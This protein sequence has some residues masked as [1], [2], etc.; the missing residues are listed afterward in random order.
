MFGDFNADIEK[1]SVFGNELVS[2]C[3]DSD[4]IVADPLFLSSGSVTHFNDGHGTESWLDHVV[5]TKGA[6]TLISDIVI[7]CTVCGSDHFPIVTTIA[8]PCCTEPVTS[9]QEAE[10]AKWTV[11]WSSIDKAR[12]NMYTL[13][14]EGRLDAVHVPLAVLDCEEES[15]GEHIEAI[16][17]Y[18]S[19]IISCLYESSCATIAK[20]VVDGKKPI[21]GW[22]EFVQKAHSTLGDIYCLW[23]MV[24]KPR[25]GYIYSQLRL[26]KARFKY[27]LRWCVKNERG[28]RAKALADK[29]ARYPHDPASF[30]KE[31][32]IARLH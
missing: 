13:G 28:L 18:Y 17:Q 25:D 19:D 32:R 23:A 14:V 2:F 20:K 22:S 4:L 3:H 8:V 9:N 30:W 11:D 7:Y 27:S 24:G 29:F 12:L 31:V 5:C 1:Q 16:D 26:A 6:V 10:I 15:F 21:P